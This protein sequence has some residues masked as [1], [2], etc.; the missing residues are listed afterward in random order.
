MQLDSI[1]ITQLQSPGVVSVELCRGT[2]TPIPELPGVAPV[3]GPKGP[4]VYSAA[5]DSTPCGGDLVIRVPAD[6]SAARKACLPAAASRSCRLACAARPW[7]GIRITVKAQAAGAKPT[8][9]SSVRFSGRVLYP[10]SPAAY[11]GM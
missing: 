9:I 3:A 1:A 7:A 10:A 11:D 6:R 8:V 2:A 5:T 4:P